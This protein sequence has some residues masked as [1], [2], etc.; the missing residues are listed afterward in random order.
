MLKHA[1]MINKL[2]ENLTI[3]RFCTNDLKKDISFSKKTMILVSN[4]TFLLRLLCIHLLLVGFVQM[5]G[6]QLF[7]LISVESYYLAVSVTKY[8]RK[9]HLRSLRFLIPKVGQSA[10]LLTFELVLFFH[11]MFKTEDRRRPVK[12]SVQRLLMNILL[13]ATLFEYLVLIVNMVWLVVELI[14]NRNQ[15]QEDFLEYEVLDKEIYVMRVLRRHALYEEH[16]K[17]RKQYLRRKRLEG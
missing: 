10:F 12:L 7:L 17:I 14:K 13:F 5:P 6:I 1:K 8:L 16:D 9:K 2:L 4:Y 3:Q 11:L 15:K